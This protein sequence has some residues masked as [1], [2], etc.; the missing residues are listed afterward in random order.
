[1]HVQQANK[2]FQVLAGGS[3]GLEVTRAACVHMGLGLSCRNPLVLA[4]EN[5][6]GERQNLSVLAQFSRSQESQELWLS[7]QLLSPTL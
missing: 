7:H 2:K 5:H 6:K 1:M 4:R 3:A